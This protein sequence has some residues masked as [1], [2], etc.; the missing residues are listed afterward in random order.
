MMCKALDQGQRRERRERR[1]R[2]KRWDRPTLPCRLKLPTLPCRLK[3]QEATSGKPG[4]YVGQPGAGE[5]V[6][7]A[8]LVS[9]GGSNLELTAIEGVGSAPDFVFGCFFSKILAFV[10]VGFAFSDT[11]LDFYSMVLPV[12]PESD[13]A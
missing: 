13:E 9:E 6:P 1:D 11:D 5:G 10:R 12:Q 2:R 7:A 4:G 8:R 3:L